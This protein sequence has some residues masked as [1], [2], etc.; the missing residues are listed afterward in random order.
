MEFSD[1][2]LS[3]EEM[4]R[5]NVLLGGETMNVD[6]A[7]RANQVLFTFG[8]NVMDAALAG[9]SQSLLHGVLSKAGPSPTFA[10]AVDV[11]TA[12]QQVRELAAS[13]GMWDEIPPIGKGPVAPVGAY[14]SRQGRTFR[15]GVIADVKAV[16]DVVRPLMR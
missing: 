6:I 8:A 10:M 3:A 9:N 16:F 2:N 1:P 5:I 11:R 4:E 7:T 14:L 15:F 12:L 13:V